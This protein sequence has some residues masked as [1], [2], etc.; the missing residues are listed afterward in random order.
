MFHRAVAFV[1]ADLIA[2]ATHIHMHTLAHM[3]SLVKPKARIRT[4]DVYLLLPGY[5]PLLSFKTRLT[6]TQNGSMCVKEAIYQ[7]RR[8]GKKTLHD[9][10]SKIVQYT[11]QQFYSTSW[12]G[13]DWLPAVK[14]A[15]YPAPF[16]K[17][18]MCCSPLSHPHWV[19]HLNRHPLWLP[20]GCKQMQFH[21]SCSLDTTKEAE[22]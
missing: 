16:R 17:T 4:T 9:V 10:N 6:N 15:S 19:L 20:N 12:T 14:P 5:M 11:L 21:I 2:M 13:S 1:N 7:K 22:A 3:H 8:E 18:A